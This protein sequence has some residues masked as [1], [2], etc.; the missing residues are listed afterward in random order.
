MLWHKAS[1]LL[2]L[3]ECFFF[4]YQISKL[5]LC[6][7]HSVVIEEGTLYQCLKT[8]VCCILASDL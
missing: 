2:V 7:R 3:G 6:L 4:F 1:R 5:I 8:N